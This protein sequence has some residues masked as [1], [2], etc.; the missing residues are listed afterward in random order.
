MTTP[1]S[2]S[3][4]AAVTAGANI[5]ETIT[6]VLPLPH[7]RIRTVTTSVSVWDSQTVMLGGPHRR[8]AGKKNQ[9][10]D[11]VLGDLPFLGRFFRSES[12]QSLKKNLMIFVTPTHH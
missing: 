2:S 5:G 10:Q 7:Y 12:S 4:Q 1:A 8:R 9:R 11:P 6:A 3:P